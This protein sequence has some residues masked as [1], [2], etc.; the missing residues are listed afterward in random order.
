MKNVMT[1]AELVV[2]V[3]ETVG[4]TYEGNERE[5]LIEKVKDCS[6]GIILTGKDATRDNQYR[7]FNVA[8]IEQLAVTVK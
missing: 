2:M 7:S 4:F 5:V 1:M 8:K 3:G 6:T